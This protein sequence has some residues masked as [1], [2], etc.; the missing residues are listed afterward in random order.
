M[1]VLLFNLKGVPDDEAEAVREVLDQNKIDF[2]ETTAGN[3]GISL[4]AIWL[5][6]KTQLIQAKQLIDTY[7]NERYQ[8]ASVEYEQLRQQGLA[9]TLASK[10]LQNPIRFII[11]LIIIG[12]IIYF[13]VMPFIYLN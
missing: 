8:Q 4:A 9:P 13:S 2:Y 12:V 1:P 10:F 5:K 3:W 7:Q 6:D 11:F